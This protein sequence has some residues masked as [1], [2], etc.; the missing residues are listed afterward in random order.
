VVF[1][2]EGAVMDNE[3]SMTIKITTREMMLLVHYKRVKIMDEGKEI[4]LVISDDGK[5]INN[6]SDKGPSR[7]D[8]HLHSKSY[9]AVGAGLQEL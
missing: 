6:S 1:P 9:Y 3:P 8:E 5:D 7:G 4:R 2:A